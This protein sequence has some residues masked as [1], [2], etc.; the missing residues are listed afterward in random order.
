MDDRVSHEVIRE[1]DIQFT[2]NA[3]NPKAL[4]K[5]LEEWDDTNPEMLF[6]LVH[7]VAD[8]VATRVNDEGLRSQLFFIR[9][10]QKD[11]AELLVETLNSVE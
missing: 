9:S 3:D 2:A 8:I 6:G 11:Y 10:I 4:A 7:D 1:A 5:K